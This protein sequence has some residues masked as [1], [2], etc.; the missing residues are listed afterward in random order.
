M[1]TSAAAQPPA[2][3]SLTSASAGE[4][5]SGVP[6]PSLTV[7]HMGENLMV[8]LPTVADADSFVLNRT[9]YEPL[10]LDGNDKSYMWSSTVVDTYGNDF[11][12]VVQP[13]FISLDVI[14]NGVV[15]DRFAHFQNCPDYVFVSA[16][17]SGQ[18]LDYSYTGP[19]LDDFGRGLGGRGQ[20]VLEFLRQEMG[21]SAS[22]LPAVAVDYPAVAVAFKNGTVQLGNA[23]AVYSDSVASGVTAAQTAVLKVINNCFNSKTRLIMFGYSQGAQV[24]GDAFT[25]L[26]PIARARVARVILFAD[27]TYRPNDNSV[28]YLPNPLNG[29]GI[30]G[31][32]EPFP[33]AEGTTVIESWCWTEDII[34]Q[35]PPENNFHGDIYDE[36]EI[37]AAKNAALALG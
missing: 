3:L 18:N 19:V 1:V 28:E 9:G 10:Q 24:I 5:Q 26:D 21:L 25:S 8:L 27:A 2:S 35:G 33:A 20:R 22:A 6:L 23:P 17:G 13:E 16:R 4:S 14:K 29:S 31:T 7:L 32:R 34:C 30:K 36:Y 12:T 11:D 37:Q 15:A